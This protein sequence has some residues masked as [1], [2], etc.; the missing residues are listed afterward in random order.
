MAKTKAVFVCSECGY[1]SPKWVGQCP[2]CHAWNSFKEFQQSNS[3]NKAGKLSVSSSKPAAAVKLKEIKAGEAERLISPY[4]EVNRVFGSGLVPGT[5]ALI[6]GEPGIGKSTL[7]LQVMMQTRNVKALYCSGE[8][9]LQQVRLRADR[10]LGEES[11]CLFT[12]ETDVDKLIQLT[13]E[14]QADLVVIDSI[15]TAFCDDLDSVAGSVSQIRDSAARIIRY[16]KTHE[17]SFLLVGHITKAGNIAGPMILEHMVDVVLQFEG[18]QNNL[19]RI[20]R[21]RKKSFWEHSGDWCLRNEPTW[22]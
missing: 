7:L 8:E 10:V 19:Y 16:A 18:D 21:A 22:T 14:S 3:K 1:E 12:D 5:V 4:A 11:E 17:V 2:S 15:Q 9:S 13:K 20:L 6:A